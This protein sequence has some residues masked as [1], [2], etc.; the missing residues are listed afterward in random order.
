[1][2]VAS[3]RVKITGIATHGCAAEMHVPPGTD[4]A[5]T[6]IAGVAKLAA[7]AGGAG[8]VAL[9]LATSADVTR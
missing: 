9:L 1:M 8:D 6:S 5:I 7:G 3:T 2:G 4:A